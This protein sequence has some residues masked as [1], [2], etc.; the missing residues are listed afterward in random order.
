LAAAGSAR[1][2]R[3][4]GNGLYGRG[5]R[6]LLEPVGPLGAGTYWRRRLVLVAVLLVVLWLMTRLGGDDRSASA[7]DESPVAQPG[8]GT[9]RPTPSPSPAG[10]DPPPGDSASGPQPAPTGTV[11]R[12]PP[13]PAPAGGSPQ[14]PRP[15]SDAD[16][17]L[18][19][20]ANATRYG[21]DAK[22]VLRLAV[23]TTGAQPCTRDL[24]PAALG[25]VIVSG[26]DRIW[27]RQDCSSAP[28]DVR[29]VTPGTPVTVE[30]TWDRVRSVPGCASAGAATRPGY[31]VATPVAGKQTG[32]PT[33]FL[34]D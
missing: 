4:G 3:S 6:A 20:T 8:A 26:Q 11:S 21:P 30:I 14:A 23:S 1:R 18:A 34:L 16:L 28:A 27:G 31:Y 9:L 13:A 2:R 5:V 17:A 19:L 25:V 12:T 22:P 29:V 10:S 15:C 33:S 32:E 24:G 7:A